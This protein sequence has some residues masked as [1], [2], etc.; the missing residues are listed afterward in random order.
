[1]NPTESEF[2]GLSHKEIPK[3]KKKHKKIEISQSISLLCAA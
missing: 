3:L 2:Y 1:M